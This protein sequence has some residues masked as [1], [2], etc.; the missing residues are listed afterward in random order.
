MSIY[1]KTGFTIALFSLLTVFSF[2]YTTILPNKVEIKDNFVYSNYSVSISNTTQETISL[3]PLLANQCSK[4]F[5]NGSITTLIPP[6]SVQNPTLLWQYYASKS[7]RIPPQE[8][9]FAINGSRP[10]KISLIYFDATQ[11]AMKFYHSSD[12]EVGKYL[13]SV[14]STDKTLNLTIKSKTTLFSP[15]LF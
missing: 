9:A 10:K 5:I 14:N 15:L 6:N 12:N 8:V 7:Y 11:N 1:I 3:T 4:L 13:I 2:S